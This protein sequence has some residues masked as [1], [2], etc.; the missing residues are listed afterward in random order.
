MESDFDFDL[1]R[2]TGHASQLLPDLTL[3]LREGGLDV[4]PK[5]Q[6]VLLRHAG[7]RQTITLSFATKGTGLLQ[8]EVPVVSLPAPVDDGIY[9]TLARWNAAA[10]GLVAHTQSQ[11]DQLRVVVRATLTPNLEAKPAFSAG[12]VSRTVDRLIE[13]RTELTSALGR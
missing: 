7:S 4:H 10:E 6:A 1:S 2:H 12:D 13:A 8:A 3:A 9:M 11:D 5:E